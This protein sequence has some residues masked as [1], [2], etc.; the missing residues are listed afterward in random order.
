MFDVSEQNIGNELVK[1]CHTRTWVVKWMISLTGAIVTSLGDTGS[2]M[3]TSSSTAPGN[4]PDGPRYMA[5]ALFRLAAGYC[6]DNVE[7]DA[8]A[9]LRPT[10]K[11]RPD[12]AIDRV[13]FLLGGGGSQ[14]NIICTGRF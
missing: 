2:L 9:P 12:V 14:L 6:G 7:G 8:G 13:F 1:V 5:V 10:G 11:P 4:H 3:Y